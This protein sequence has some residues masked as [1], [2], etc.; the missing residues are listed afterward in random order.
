M[1]PLLPGDDDLIFW[2]L[3]SSHF[4]TRL[5]T[6]GWLF[7]T[8]LVLIRF[9][10]GQLLGPSVWGLSTMMATA[11]LTPSLGAWADQTDRC[12]VVTLGVAA[13]AI[14]VLGSTVVLVV[15]LADGSNGDS[16]W[17]GLLAFTAFSVVEMLGT[18]LSDVAVKREWAPRLFEGQ[19]LKRTNSLMSQIDLVSKALGPFLAGLLVTP[20]LGFLPSEVV[21]FL[22]VGMLN[23][24]S[25]PP[26]LVLL[27][28]IYAARAHQLQPLKASEV[29]RQANPLAPKGGAWPAWFR[30]PSGIQ[31]LSLS[32]SLLYLTVLAPPGAFL[33]AH[34]AEREVPNY[35]LALFRGS[36]ALLGVAGVFV[37]PPVCRILGHRAADALFVT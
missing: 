4:I 16:K 23:V 17:L 32:Y 26:Q 11:L 25:F 18:A 36:G 2:Q 20:S 1:E 33:T 27:R 31:F 29:Q 30:H 19:R 21:G 9:T 7:I 12:Q 34:L 28:R 35:Q 10:P 15:T 24:L 5:A 37:H 8:N 13:Q 3:L 14:A 22:A 6:Q